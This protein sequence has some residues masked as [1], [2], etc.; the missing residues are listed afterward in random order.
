MKLDVP[1][2]ESTQTDGRRDAVTQRHRSQRDR[3]VA[4]RGVQA[5]NPRG[6]E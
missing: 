4:G 1:G 6:K 3:D 2:D 5:R